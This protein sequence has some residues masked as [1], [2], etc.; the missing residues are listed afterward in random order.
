MIIYTHDISKETMAVIMHCV[1]EETNFEIMGLSEILISF[2]LLKKWI[3]IMIGNQG[4]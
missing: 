1:I 2:S 4:D 3:I